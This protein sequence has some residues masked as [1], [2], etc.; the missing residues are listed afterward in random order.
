MTT[1]DVGRV[2]V[3]RTRPFAWWLLVVLEVVIAVN[4]VY[5]GIGLMVNGMG[6]RGDWL[7]GTPFQSWTLPGVLLLVV[8]AVPMSL[9][10]VGELAR[11]RLAYLASFT[12]GLVLIGWIAA[13]VLV[14][15]R[16][17]FLQP[18]L[19]VAGCVVV[20]LAWWAHRRRESLPSA[21]QR[22]RSR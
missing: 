7:D 3:P 4:A 22:R 9:A 21:H 15:R 1:A 2:G 10:A 12:A 8:I 5:G 13:Q 11:W 20:G 17:F 16:Y 19:G 6:M 18:V 14:L